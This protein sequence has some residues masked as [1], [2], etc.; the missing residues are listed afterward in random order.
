M[1][2]RDEKD[3]KDAFRLFKTQY[4]SHD[5][6][7]TNFMH[8]IFIDFLHPDFVKDF[9]SKENLYTFPKIFAVVYPLTRPGLG[10]GMTFSEGE[11]WARKRKIFN[12][13]FNF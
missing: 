2:A 11:R 12:R 7:V 3:H 1:I 4:T 9:Y 10:G 8:N 5:V 13:V 6:A